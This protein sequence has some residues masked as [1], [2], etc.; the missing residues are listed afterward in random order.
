MNRPVTLFTGR[1]ADLPISAEA[2]TRLFDAAFST[3]TPVRG[4]S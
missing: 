2:S 4:Q 1:W 3:T